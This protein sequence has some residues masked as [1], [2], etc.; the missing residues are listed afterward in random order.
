MTKLELKH[1]APYL[2]Y[3]LKIYHKKEV[4]ELTGIKP[5]CGS[6]MLSF[7]GVGIAWGYI[8]NC[9]PILR[10]LS[11]LTKEYLEKNHGI[12]NEDDEGYE[13]W[14]RV[15]YSHK[16][17]EI[18][19]EVHWGIVNELIKNNIDVFNLIPQGLAININ[20]IEK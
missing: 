8:N 20:D 11:D 15:K 18:L 7:D 17:P 2:P 5:H 16:E 13:M 12:V 1:L 9:K 3:G 10:P 14:M 4:F 6:T 19:K